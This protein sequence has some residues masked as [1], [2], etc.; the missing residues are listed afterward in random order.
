MQAAKRNAER[1]L[2]VLQPSPHRV[3]LRR[4]LHPI[5]REKVH[6]ATPCPYDV[7]TPR[8]TKLLV[9]IFAAAPR[10]QPALEDDGTVHSKRLTTPLPQALQTT[11]SPTSITIQPRLLNQSCQLANIFSSGCHR[12]TDFSS[13]TGDLPLEDRHRWSIHG[14]L[15]GC[16][17]CNLKNATG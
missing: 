1:T 17:N 4:I 16:C 15:I 9:G 11:D 10:I 14:R 7:A 13:D 3:V 5:Q 8:H 2:N 12:A 6:R